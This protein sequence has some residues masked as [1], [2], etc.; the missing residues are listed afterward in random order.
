MF[1]PVRVEGIFTSTL[2][3]MRKTAS[4]DPGEVIGLIRAASALP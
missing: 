2:I 3:A 1:I 4:V